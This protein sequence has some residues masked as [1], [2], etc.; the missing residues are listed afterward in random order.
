MDSG[1]TTAKVDSDSEGGGEEDEALK[2]LAG[3][4]FEFLS[5]SRRRHPR[6]QIFRS[7]KIQAPFQNSQEVLENL[8]DRGLTTA[9]GR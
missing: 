3:M 5:P 8:M 6:A 4:T 2:N 1:L 9:Q 7:R